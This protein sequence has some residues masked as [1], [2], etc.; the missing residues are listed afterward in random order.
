M[1]IGFT[2]HV[3]H[4]V[5][6]RMIAK[7]TDGLTRGIMLEGVV[8][9]EDM[10]SFIDLSK[11]ALE[12][13]PALLEFMQSWTTPILGETKVFSLSGKNSLRLECNA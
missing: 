6:T 7:G 12:K 4:I 2:L 10:L 3:V 5:G 1:D 11:T 13:H 9:G 8:K